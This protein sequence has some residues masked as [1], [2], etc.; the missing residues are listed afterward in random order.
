ME[1]LITLLIF[2]LFFS[3]VG[4]ALQRLEINQLHRT[5]NRMMDKDSLKSF[6]EDMWKDAIDE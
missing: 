1:Y 6:S 5:L 2:G 4:N 3:L